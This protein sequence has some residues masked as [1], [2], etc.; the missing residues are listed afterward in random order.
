MKSIKN[1][2]QIT[3]KRILDYLKGILTN[4]EKNRLERDAMTDPFESDAFDGLSGLSA[5]E[6]DNDLSE[7]KSQLF[8]KKE[9]RPI[10]VFLRIA[11]IVFLLLIPSFSIWYFITFNPKEETFA[12]VKYNQLDSSFTLKKQIHEKITN[13]DSTNTIKNIITSNKKT[14]PSVQKKA[15]PKQRV[16]KIEFDTDKIKK[17]EAAI[18]KEDSPIIKN[19]KTFD[20]SISGNVTDE[21]NQPLPGV[22]I[23]L[24]DESIGTIS[25]TNGNYSIQTKNNNDVLVANYIGYKSEEASIIKDSI[26]NFKLNPEILALDEVVTVSYNKTKQLPSSIIPPKPVIGMT[27][28]HNYIEKQ[29]KYLSDSLQNKKIAIVI[30]TISYD[31]SIK[32][33]NI[34]KSPGSEYSEEIINAIKNGPK[35]IAGTKDGITIES[36]RKIRLVFKPN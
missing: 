3:P 29:L 23:M 14:I 28:Y 8:K 7:I 21:D 15:T 26:I 27:E 22:T 24:K 34:E 1:N 31:G 18:K 6:L 10:T 35:W 5:N 2:N 11:S 20:K 16:R 12:D 36:K 19:N 33:V 25:D 4:Q 9:L 13:H 17:T 32:S 30:I